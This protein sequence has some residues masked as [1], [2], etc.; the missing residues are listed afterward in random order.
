MPAVTPKKSRPTPKQ[1]KQPTRG[2]GRWLYDLVATMP[3][4]RSGPGSNSNHETGDRAMVAAESRRERRTLHLFRAFSRRRQLVHGNTLR[5]H[6][7][8]NTIA[9]DSRRARI[10][11]E[12]EDAAH[13]YGEV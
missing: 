11:Q 8:R 9:A 12:Q 5:K 2:Q 1:V 10:R 6:R 7:T 3:K 13:R 4:P